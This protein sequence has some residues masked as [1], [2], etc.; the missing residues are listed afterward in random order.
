[1]DVDLQGLAEEVG[2]QF[3]E[4]NVITRRTG[5]HAGV[6]TQSEDSFNDLEG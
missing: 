4:V 1:M 6:T 5:H 2:Q 3:T